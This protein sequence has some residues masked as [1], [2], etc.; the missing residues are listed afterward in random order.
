LLLGSHNGNAR[1]SNTV[2][3]K[4]AIDFDFDR[5]IERSN[6]NSVKFDALKA[7]FGSED[8]LPM[9][10]AD[11]DFA[12]PEA[13]VQALVERAQH[14]VYGYSLYP[15]GLYE[16]M[17]DWFAERHS[18]RIDRD[19]I[20]IAPGVVP[21]LHAVAMAFAAPGEGIVVQPPVYPPFF[22][23]AAKTGRSLVINPLVHRDGEYTMDLEQ[24][25]RCASQARI[26]ALCSPHNPAG[27]VWRESELQD[28][29]EIARRHNLLIL[30]DDIHCD[31]TFPGHR[32]T[33]LASLATEQDQIITAVAPSKTFNI[34][35]MGLSAL[36]VPDPA[37]R[38]ALKTTFEAMHI[39]PAN[40]FSIVAFEAAYRHG[41]PWLDALLEYL[42]GN[43]QLVSRYLAAHLPEIRMDEPEGTY[44]LWLDCSRLGMSD[45]ELKSFFIHQARVGMN[46]GTSFGD[47]GS[48]YMRL[49]IGTQRAVVQEALERIA[50]AVRTLKNR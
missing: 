26:L 16:S 4:A 37:H 41:G 10:V 31:L 3:V 25:E 8:V 45:A 2:A 50:L 13:V 23:A 48:G 22:A 15:D 30:S 14:P 43:V 39:E 20:M 7:V 46:P 18:W 29:L 47:A 33:M 9:W 11:T 21:S 32:H 49:N 35:G 40:P 19:W 36:V 38:Q 24:L 1:E 42:Q 34:A 44:L 27:R 5:Q 6:T 28:M 17:I 12:A